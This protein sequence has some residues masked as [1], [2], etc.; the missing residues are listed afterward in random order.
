MSD[1]PTGMGPD[2][3]YTRKS[4]ETARLASSPDTSRFDGLHAD[5]ERAVDAAAVGL[6]AVRE[7]YREAYLDELARWHASRD[8]LDRRV[9]DPDAPRL[10][11]LQQEVERA[12]ALLGQHQQ[13]LSRLELAQQALERTAHFL[14]RGDASLVADPSDPTLSTDVRMRIVE[15]QEQERSRLA[16]EI[17][18]G[19]AQALTNAIFQ[20]EYL[21]RVIGED[22]RVAA[23]ELRFLR[24]LLRRELGEV[25][26]SILNLRP[27]LLDH[28]GLDEAIAD[29][30]ST[31]AGLTGLAIETD[32]QAPGDR[33]D[34]SVRMVALRVVQE[35]L[36]NVRKHAAATRV[37]VQTRLIDGDWTLEVVDDG[38]GFDPTS[39]ALAG[40]RH[41][42]LRFMRERAELIGARLDVRSGPG[43][44]TI[45]R[46]AVPLGGERR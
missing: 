30:A 1:E 38:L 18:D 16:Q 27:P 43:G 12:T 29:T 14:E 44:G 13:E 45:V 24:E 31:V 39:V 32:L 20:V 46:L 34:A 23:T 40:G 7:R 3:P 15:A 6:R 35:A 4:M 37:V 9:A 33:L 2:E 22:G 26:S 25:R 19:P 36:Q 28:L 41:F 5:A 17:H 8:E 42:G 11:E 10:P 21:E